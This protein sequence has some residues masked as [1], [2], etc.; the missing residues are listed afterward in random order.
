MQSRFDVQEG[1]TSYITYIMLVFDISILLLASAKKIKCTNLV[2]IGLLI[3]IVPATSLFLPEQLKQNLLQK[4]A[5]VATS[6]N[7]SMF[8]GVDGTLIILWQDI[9]HNDS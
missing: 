3:H 5:Q 2:H 8:S 1:N 6:N 7:H 9:I 4:L